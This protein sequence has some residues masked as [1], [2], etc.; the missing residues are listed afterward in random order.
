MIRFAFKITRAIAQKYG[1]HF[2]SCMLT[3]FFK[4]NPVSQQVAYLQSNAD[5]RLSMDL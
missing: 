4:M 2:L 1:K 3:L 5:F